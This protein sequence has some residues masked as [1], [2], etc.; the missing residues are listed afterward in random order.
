M[1]LDFIIIGAVVLFLLF[2]LWKLSRQKKLSPKTIIQYSAK[3]RKTA[4]LDPAHAIMESHKI[5]VA[6]LSNL[7]KN[8]KLTAA[9]KIAKIQKRLPNI[10]KIWR[11][12]GFRN[13]IAH[14]TDVRVSKT[15]AS[16]A[17]KD[18]IKALESLG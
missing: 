7:F 16:S 6:A 1:N 13:K 3:I 18:F 4:S 11:H 5:F 17:R 8:K 10:A 14:E 15:Q 12:H 2:I 9:Q